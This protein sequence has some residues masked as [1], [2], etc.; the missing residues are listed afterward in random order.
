MCDIKYVD[1]YSFVVK[2]SLHL[3]LLY[4]CSFVKLFKHRLVSSSCPLFMDCVFLSS[5]MSLMT[6]HTHLNFY[7]YPYVLS[8]NGSE[9]VLMVTGSAMGR[10]QC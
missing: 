10:T 4:R 8:V 9:H 7:C 2:I 5:S 1:V 6:S 3:K